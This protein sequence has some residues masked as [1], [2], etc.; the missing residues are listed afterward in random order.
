MDI[1]YDFKAISISFL[2]RCKKYFNLRKI[3]KDIE[4]GYIINKQN[5]YSQNSRSSLTLNS[6]SKGQILVKTFSSSIEGTESYLSEIRAINIFKQYPWFPKVISISGK[7][8]FYEYIPNMYRLD[9][10]GQFL[11]K[12]EK[13]IIKKKILNIL[14]TMYV[15]NISHRDIH[16]KNIFYFNKNVVLIDYEYIIENVNFEEF[17]KSYDIIAKN[18]KSPAFTNE[19]CLLNNSTY[20]LKHILNIN[21]IKDI[22]ETM[23]E[24]ILDQ[25]RN[26]SSSFFTRKQ[27]IE[28]RLF[29]Q[30][31]SIYSTFDLKYTNVNEILGQR[32]VKKRL[33]NF[34][35]KSDSI[36]GYSVLDLGC[37]TGGIAFEISKLN[38]KYILGIEYD[39]EKV[40]VS[41]KIHALN[42]K[43]S[44]IKF[45]NL[46]LESDEF[47]NKFN[48]N[49]DIVFC[50]AVIGHI[51]NKSQFMKKIFSICK[52]IL[53]FE[54]NGNTTKNE[55][56]LLLLS[57]GF[58]E[59]N[60]CGYSN[61]E[62]DNKN[63][64][65]LFIAKK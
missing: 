34:W 35:I 65:P 10:I 6:S 16:T 22:Q 31:N 28:G 52:K 26:C 9:Q 12:N 21:S 64:R 11:T 36:K 41:E 46:D 51:K 13:K 47:L 53:Y 32:S 8:I 57:A 29:T 33:E 39:L 45:K 17:F 63:K 14:L 54:G 43:Y 4:F 62:K 20:S 42:C 27:L 1:V 23:Q 19:M 44:N 37:N 55:L 18:H 25:L 49:F 38:P 59:I 61:D 58:C 24:E 48:E 7:S 56:E 3:R 40:Q 5:P 50:L 30:K 15:H 60:F 2:R